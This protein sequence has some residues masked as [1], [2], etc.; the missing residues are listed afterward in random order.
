MSKQGAGP[1]RGGLEEAGAGRAEKLALTCRWLWVW[2][3]KGQ[4]EEG[5]VGLRC[6]GS[7]QTD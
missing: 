4:E 7:I 1:S 3:A 5:A 2:G 6:Q